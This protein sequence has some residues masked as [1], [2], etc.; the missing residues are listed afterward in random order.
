MADLTITPANVAP[1]SSTAR[2]ET[3]LFASAVT[4][5]QSVCR[6]Q[7]QA[8]RPADANEAGPTASE[9]AGQ[10]GLGIALSS[11]DSN[12]PGIVATEGL[13]DV[14]ATLTVGTAYYV[15]TNAGGVAP[16][17][18]IAA[19]AAGTKISLLGVAVATNRLALNPS[20][21]VGTR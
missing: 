19:A 15:S 11:G 8:W 14:G 7:T 9:A 2:I 16:G 3:A 6:T 13:I 21:Q 20:A 4:A 18:D 5:G 12:T 10:R 1:R 17:A